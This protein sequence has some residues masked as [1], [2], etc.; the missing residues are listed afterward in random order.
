MQKLKRNLQV[1]PCLTLYRITGRSHISPND[2]C[3]KEAL[4]V[5]VTI[6]WTGLLDWNTGLDY[7]T[8]VFSFFG[9]DYVVFQIFDNGRPQSLF[10]ETIEFL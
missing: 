3:Q 5:A 2:I 7:W 1:V 4:G 6:H 10:L 9:Q 8:E